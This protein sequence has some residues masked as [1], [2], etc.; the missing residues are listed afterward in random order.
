MKQDMETKTADMNIYDFVT[1]V[2]LPSVTGRIKW[3]ADTTLPKGGLS[4]PWEYVSVA[5]R[6]PVLIVKNQ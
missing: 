6:F 4:R 3:T 1:D 5:S 2:T